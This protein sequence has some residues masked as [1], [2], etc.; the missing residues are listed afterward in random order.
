VRRPKGFSLR[1]YVRE[2][3]FFAYPLQGTVIRLD[4]LFEQKAAV[5]LSERPL[6]RD[7]RLTVWR[8]GRM[9]LQAS[10]KD[11]LELRWWLLGFGDKVE[12]LV[13]KS[14]RTEFS[15]IACRMAV[16]YQNVLTGDSAA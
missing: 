6:A 7:Q 10:V 8:D 9:R 4:A 13:P 5:H 12:V 1:R 3:Q 14:L 15:A 16:Q 11:T 2:E